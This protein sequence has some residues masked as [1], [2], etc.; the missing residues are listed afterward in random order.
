MAGI[1]LS[2]SNSWNLVSDFLSGFIWGQFIHISFCATFSCSI[3]SCFPSL[4]YTP[5]TYICRKQLYPALQRRFCQAKQDKLFCHLVSGKALHYPNHPGTHSLHLLQFQSSCVKMNNQNYILLW[6]SSLLEL[7]CVNRVL[8][9]RLHYIRHFHNFITAGLYLKPNSK[10]FCSKLGAHQLE[11]TRRRNVTH[12]MTAIRHNDMCDK[13]VKKAYHSLRYIKQ[14]SISD[15]VL[16][17]PGKTSSGVLCTTLVTYVKETLTDTGKM[18]IN[19]TRM[20]NEME[21]QSYERRLCTELDLFSVTKWRLA[22]DKIALYRWIKKVN[23]NRSMGRLFKSKNFCTRTV[24]VR[25]PGG[26]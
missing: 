1:K 23:T 18:Q 22:E 7:T 15:I 16:Q 4:G 26:N 10:N 20:I 9:L 25:W 14:G 5:I 11:I 2:C 17:S 6:M 21:N 13:A 3:N 19:A 24:S 8:L 12:R